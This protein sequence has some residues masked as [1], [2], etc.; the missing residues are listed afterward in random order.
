MCSIRFSLVFILIG[1]VQFV[2]SIK[3]G[4]G[5]EATPISPLIIHVGSLAEF[6]YPLLTCLASQTYFVFDDR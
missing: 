5:N 2:V 6:L 4:P 1:V 3:I